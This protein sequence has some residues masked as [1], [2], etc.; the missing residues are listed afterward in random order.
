MLL[1][2]GLAATTYGF[3]D[4]GRSLQEFQCQPLSIPS[5]PL[6]AT[7]TRAPVEDLE[8]VG[9]DDQ[10]VFAMT[11]N[12]KTDKG[13]L[14]RSKDGGS[15][16]DEFTPKLVAD[17]SETFSIF[18]VFHQ[19]SNPNNMLFMGTGSSMW[20]SNDK[21]ETLRNVSYPGGVLGVYI[22]DLRFNPRND[23]S[24]LLHVKRAS[25]RVKERVHLDC[26]RD[27][28]VN[29]NVFDPS[30][31]WRNLTDVTGG[32]IAGFVDFDWGA[33][34]CPD[35]NCPDLPN[36][37]NDL[38]LATVYFNVEDYD[39]T[40]DKDISLVTSTNLFDSWEVR[41]PCGNQLEVVGRSV[42]L[43]VANSCE[44]SPDGSGSYIT[45]FTSVDG[46]AN[47]V[48]ACLPA[49]LE[50]DGYELVET[51]DGRGALIIVDYSVDRGM[52]MP[53]SA[54]SVYAAGPH[55]ALFSLSLTNVFQGS[56]AATADFTR[57]EGLPGIYITNQVVPYPST[58]GSTGSTDP[59]GGGG[60]MM[61]SDMT[62][63]YL[64]Y[65]GDPY[66]DLSELMGEPL[67]ET[68]ITYSAGGRW[69]RIRVDA[70]RV[71]HPRCMGTGPAPWYLHL[72]GM[73]AANEFSV[74]LP[75]VYSSTSAPGLVMA[76]GNLASLG[77]GLDQTSPGLCTWLSRDGGVTWEDVAEGAYIYEFADWGG[78]IVM[79]KYPG[80]ERYTASGTTEEVMF[81]M[82]Y[83]RCWE[84]VKLEKPIYVDNIRIE[85]DGQRPTVIIH[86]RAPKNDSLNLNRY[87]G[88]YVR[89]EGEQRDYTRRKQDSKCFN[90]PDYKRPEAAVRGT[91]NCTKQLDTEC[92]Y[93]YVRSNDTCVA[94]PSTSMPECPVVADGVY[95]VSA[96]G[97]RLVHGDVCLNTTA[98][99]PDTNGRGQST[100]SGDSGRGRRTSTSH[101]GWVTVLVL[102]LVFG[103]LAGGAVA[104]WRYRA[105][106][107][108]QETVREM[109]G[110]AAA[111]VASAWGLLVDKIR[112]TRYRYS[113]PAQ[114]A[115][116]GEEMGYFQP[117]G[118]PGYDV[119]GRGTI[120]TLR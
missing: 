97:L 30:S 41:V 81:S 37:S 18:K 8:W 6:K 78:V 39:H 45:L 91:C 47:F 20:I 85:P 76:T 28:L 53:M 38:I 62:G 113:S 80:L 86:G 27:L 103:V 111:A 14:W 43:A 88:P 17:S 3:T 100:A 105:T 114:G 40:W 120:F 15:N 118:D 24:L 99:I 48:R 70:S 25:C 51:H 71:R 5:T 110:S 67:I 2:I 65:Y 55:H 54:A 34:L 1:V 36:I 108:Q 87:R 11:Y 112:A 60:G 33:N 57:V 109:A 61:P 26:P 4:H 79:A 44:R 9:D 73:G 52:M 94:I 69:Q 42:Y 95:T 49:A 101:G 72:N 63:D 56:L 104:W 16:F 102:L 115:S 31:P 23:T 35:N 10:T 32:K 82:D 96:T 98:F 68:R 90:G 66:Y 93:G 29:T 50:Q 7:Q 64:D 75:G 92:D 58:D 106:D 12:V 89:A 59:T 83:G 117:L 46:G 107:D 21:G 22:R 119:E 84:K 13:G 77:S 116:S 19:K 74:V